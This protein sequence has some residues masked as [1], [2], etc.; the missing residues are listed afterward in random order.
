MQR[1]LVIS[2]LAAIA[3]VARAGETCVDT[4]HAFPTYGADT[5]LECWVRQS[6]EDGTPVPSHTIC[7]RITQAAS[8]NTNCR[9][10]PDPDCEVGGT[11]FRWRCTSSR[12]RY[13]GSLS[14]DGRG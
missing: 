10:V 12:S 6:L 7:K 2:F 14:R 13:G 4:A 1:C 8:C 9:Q 3:F 11:L 5:H